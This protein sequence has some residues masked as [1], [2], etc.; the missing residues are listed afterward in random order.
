[1]RCP[2][3][4]AELEQKTY[5]S[6]VEIDQCPQ[7]A[8]IF[9]D[10]GELETIQATIEKDHRRDAA[11]S[12][13]TSWDPVETAK[14]DVRGPV[15]CVKCGAR[16]ERRRYGFGSQTV[17]DECPKG[18]GVWLDGG[19]IQELERFYEES[20]QEVEIPIT[21]RIWAAVRGAMSKRSTR[22]T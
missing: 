21:W 13:D 20:Q 8:G 3:D 2:R 10:K 18:C 4:A 7:C 12:A 11:L 9:L 19:E 22:A 5:E 17:I 1:M 16:M 15:D 14:G 6:T